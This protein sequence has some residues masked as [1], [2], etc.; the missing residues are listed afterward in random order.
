M[1]CV[2]YELKIKPGKEQMFRESW[3][4]VST[5]IIDS[6]ESLGARLHKSDTGSWIAYAQW[7]DEHTWQ[8]GH[9]VV[10][11]LAEQDHMEEYLDGFEILHKLIL[12]EDLLVRT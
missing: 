12:I 6:C 3:H 8:K 7:P 5:A 9:L 4:H 1:F 2:I 10:D 11:K